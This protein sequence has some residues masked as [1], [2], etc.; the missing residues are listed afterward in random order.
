MFF[1]IAGV[2]Y[3][4][5]L[6]LIV[7]VLDAVP[8]VGAALASLVGVAVALSQSWGLAVATLIFFCVY[9]AVENYLVAPRVFSR[10]IELSPAPPSS[11]S[12]SGPRWAGSSVP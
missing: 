7:A 2:P 3:P 1:A 11:P 5:L 4:A 10:T 12:W 6:A 9:Q 8:Q